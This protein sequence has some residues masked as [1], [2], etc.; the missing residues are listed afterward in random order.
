MGG[1]AAFAVRPLCLY[2]FG[3]GA[4][5]S[6]AVQL[7]GTGEGGGVGDF[8]NAV[9]LGVVSVVNIAKEIVLLGVFRGDEAE[10]FFY[11]TEG[12]ELVGARGGG[13]S[14]FLGDFPTA[15][16]DRGAVDA[17]AFGDFGAEMGDACADGRIC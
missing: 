13:L 5:Q 9:E 10:G 8:E 17:E 15:D 14:A 3:C 7:C 16:E 2:G 4:L 6:G 1:R 11:V 12:G